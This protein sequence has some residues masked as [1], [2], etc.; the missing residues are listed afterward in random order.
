VKGQKGCSYSQF[1][2][3]KEFGSSAYPYDTVPCQVQPVRYNSSFKH[4]H[5]RKSDIWEKKTQRHSSQPLAE[6]AET[7]PVV[8]PTNRHHFK[9]W[10]GHFTTRE[11]FQIRAGRSGNRIPVGAK[12][13]APLHTGPGAYPA[14]YKCV[15]GLF[16]GGKAVGAWR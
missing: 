10:H 4:L 9:G 13:S 8:R 16:P 6:G 11:H 15:P 12:F 2:L 3:V 5:Y 14:S 7:L 1:I